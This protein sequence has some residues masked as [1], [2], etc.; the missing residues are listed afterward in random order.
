MMTGLAVLTFS[1]CNDFLD[2]T[3]L[4]AVA[5]EQYLQNAAQLQAYVDKYYS[6]IPS[7]EGSGGESP[8]HDDKATDNNQGTNNRYILNS[9]TVGQTG[10]D[11]SFTNIYAFNYFIQ[12]AGPRV[13]SGQI[14][15]TEA[16][17]YLGEGYFLRALEYFYRLRRLGDFPIV[18]EILPDDQEVLTEA[19]ARQPRNL[20]ARFIL[21]DLDKAISLL[22]NDMAKTR[23]SKNAALI[24]KSRVA[25]Y[26]ASWEKYHAG[27]PFVPDKNAGWPGAAKDYNANFAY[28]N[29]G[30]VNFFLTQ[31]MDAASKVADALPLV[32]NSKVIRQSTADAKNPYYDMFA[33]HNPTGYSEVVMCRLYG[34]NIS[35]HYY[36]HYIYHGGQTGYT[37]QFE[38]SFLMQNGLPWYAAGSGYKGD[39][40]ISYTKEDRDWRWQLFM[41]GPNDVIGVDNLATPERLP[42]EPEVYQSDNKL[43][44]STGYIQGKGHSQ[45]FN[46]QVLGKDLTSFVVFRAAEAYLN[47]IEACYMKNGSLDGN[48]DKYWR[49]LRTRAGVDPD[50]TK[51]IDATDMSI[52]AE[53]DWG[54]YSAGKVIDKTLYNIRR[55]R[56][57]E[58]IGEGFRLND[59]QRWRALDQLD[60]FQQKGAHIFSEEM[61]PLFDGKLLY[62]QA[63]DSKNNVSSPKDSEW[64]LPNRKTKSSQYYNGFYHYQ[65]H[66]L[67][68]I[69]VQHFLITAPDGKSVDQSPIYQNPYWPIAAGE[70]CENK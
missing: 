6:T 7:A 16:K 64:L 47:Y 50:Y 60:G 49:A 51:T 41:L 57:C 23:I 55:E 66:Y 45:D 38:K 11:W 12:T 27:T 31:A 1:S 29:A 63:D 67:Q 14:S 20:V 28:D 17:H 25:L 37:A 35:T 40:L 30:E 18:T 52:E 43:S 59:L 39:N 9:W 19:S 70:V 36:N 58:F 22:T 13:E 2:Q 15:G 54:A 62:D 68:P 32:N 34:E 24:L 5:P 21:E 46:D 61:M 10:G 44:T 4:N 53:N 26:E 65:A 33:S 69:A 3:P 56:R 8:Y 42:K 48:A